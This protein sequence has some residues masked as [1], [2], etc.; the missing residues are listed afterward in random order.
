MIAL[1]L[2]SVVFFLLFVA[3]IAHFR[4]LGCL[5]RAGIS[6]KYLANASDSFRAY[7]KYREMAKDR[8]WP[9]WPFYAALGGY[10]GLFLAGLFLLLGSRIAGLEKLAQTIFKSRLLSAAGLLWV[11]LTSL[12]TGLWFTLRM[13]RS[14]RNQ[15]KPV[16]SGSFTK[17]LSESESLRNDFYGALLSWTGCALALVLLGLLGVQ[18]FLN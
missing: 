11:F 16:V 10:S 13:L 15:G 17:L 5:E 3:T 1:V 7:L 2:I 14:L 9:V 6:V 18:Q 12:G 8:G 4:I